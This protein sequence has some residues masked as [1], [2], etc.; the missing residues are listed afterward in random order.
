MDHETTTCGRCGGTGKYSFNLMHGSRCYGCGG[1]GKALT[2]RGQ[3]ARR[4]LQALYLRPASEIAV[5]EQVR[6]SVGMLGPEKWHR[7]TAV[8]SYNESGDIALDLK[9]GSHEVKRITAPHATLK[10]V[11]DQAHLDQ[12][13]AAAAAYEA[14]L[15]EDG[16]PTN[17]TRRVGAHF[18]PIPGEPHLSMIV[19]KASDGEYV[20]GVQ[21]DRLNAFGNIDARDTLAQA[22]R[23]A[24]ELVESCHYR[25]LIPTPAAAQAA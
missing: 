22:K 14:S 20:I 16:K 7:V 17:W 24:Q 19:A 18:L 12:L 15:D 2:K 6:E 4:F 25:G 8:G 10:S 21:D 11:R 1:T 23:R 3:R 9:R 13:I 5:G